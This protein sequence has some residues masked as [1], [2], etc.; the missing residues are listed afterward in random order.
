[1]FLVH[2][3]SAIAHSHIFIL[4]VRS[5]VCVWRNELNTG[6]VMIVSGKFYPALMWVESIEVGLIRFW[7]I[8]SETLPAAHQS[9]LWIS[10]IAHVNL[11]IINIHRD[12]PP[13]NCFSQFERGYRLSRLSFW[14]RNR[15]AGVWTVSACMFSMG[16]CPPLYCSGVVSEWC[17]V[18]ICSLGVLGLNCCH[19]QKNS[20]ALGAQRYKKLFVTPSACHVLSSINITYIL[21]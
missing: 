17:V 4:F 7:S 11:S 14:S 8:G 16:V 9:F 12:V 20:A 2:Y 6:L 5:C 18:V 19:L 1:M 15:A 21:V 3:K 10:L 13:P